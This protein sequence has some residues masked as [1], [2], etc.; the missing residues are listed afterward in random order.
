MGKVRRGDMSLSVNENVNSE[1]DI[2]F[3]D[4][5]TKIGNGMNPESE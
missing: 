2:T 4:T 1:E 3:D 5:V